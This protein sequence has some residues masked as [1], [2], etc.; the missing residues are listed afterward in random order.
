MSLLKVVCE[1]EGD[2]QLLMCLLQVVCKG[3]VD[4]QF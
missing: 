3:E 1:G 2:K 4:K